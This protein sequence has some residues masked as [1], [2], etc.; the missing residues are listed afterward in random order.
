MQAFTPRWHIMSP[1]WCANFLNFGFVSLGQFLPWTSDVLLRKKEIV[2]LVAVNLIVDDDVRILFGKYQVRANI[3]YFTL[4]S[5]CLE[6]SSP[7][8]ESFVNTVRA[9]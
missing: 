9:V 4:A 7:V 5:W 8:A 3:K 2:F 1:S 6:C